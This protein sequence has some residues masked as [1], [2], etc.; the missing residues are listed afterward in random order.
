MRLTTNFHS[1]LKKAE[2]VALII[3]VILMAAATSAVCADIPEKTAE[4]RVPSPNQETPEAFLVWAE[5]SGE[6][7]EIFLSKLTRGAWSPKMQV[8]ENGDNNIVPAVIRDPDGA[9]WIVWTKVEGAA[10]NL[11][12]RTFDGTKWSQERKIET[13]LDI[14]LAAALVADKENQLWLF[15]ASFDGVDDDIFFSRWD[16]SGWSRAERVNRDDVTPDIQPYAGIGSDGLPW[17]K[18]RGFEDGEYRQFESRWTGTD[19]TPEETMPQSMASDDVPSE[20]NAQPQSLVNTQPAEIVT[21]EKNGQPTVIFL[22]DFLSDPWKAGICIED[23]G[24]VTSQPLRT[25]LNAEK[26]K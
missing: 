11:Y 2:T 16:G 20:I 26:T 22:P 18:W 24:R 9:L 23:R 4:T 12:Y 13:G 1:G 5:N 10:R 17:V 15:W 3:S 21:G 7:Y 19:W 6:N 14:N 25:L 8:T